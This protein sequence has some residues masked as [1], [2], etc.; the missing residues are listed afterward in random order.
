MGWVKLLLYRLALNTEL[1]NLN[2]VGAMLR[3]FIFGAAFLFLSFCK[4]KEVMLYCL[5]HLQLS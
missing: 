1:G 4:E 3:T 2:S 5:I